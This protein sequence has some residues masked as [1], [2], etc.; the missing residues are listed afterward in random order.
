LYKS[1]FDEIKKKSDIES[2][3]LS[4]EELKQKKSISRANFDSYLNDLSSR[5]SLKESRA[6]IENRLNIESIGFYEVKKFLKN[7]L[8]YEIKRMT[9]NDKALISLEKKIQLIINSLNLDLNEGLYNSM[10]VVLE[11]T[12]KN[13]ILDPTIDRELLKSIILHKLYE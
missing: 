6:S 7:S 10:E 1:I 13:M 11:E 2:A 8:N 5:T 4:F 3:M 9:Y 12:L